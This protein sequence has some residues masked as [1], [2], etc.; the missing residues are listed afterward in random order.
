[1][2]YHMIRPGGTMQTHQQ[3]WTPATLRTA[4]NHLVVT[5]AD[6]DDILQSMDEDFAITSVGSAKAIHV[7][8]KFN[9]NRTLLSTIRRLFIDDQP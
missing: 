7:K 1:M 5:E 4:S 3:D 2:V 8:Y 9:K 6:L